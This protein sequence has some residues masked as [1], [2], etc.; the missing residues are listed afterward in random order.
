MSRNLIKL[1]SARFQCRSITNRLLS[2][3]YRFTAD[4]NSMTWNVRNLV[5]PRYQCKCITKCFLRLYNRFT[6]YYNFMT[7]NLRKLITPRFQCTSIKNRVFS[8]FD[9]FT[10]IFAISVHK[11]HKSFLSLTDR[12]SLFDQKNSYLRDFS[13]RVLI[14]LL[15]DLKCQKTH[16]SSI[17][18]HNYHKSCS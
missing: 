4:Y 13:A 8:L 17:S 2:L 14:T 7:W 15:Y 18:V 12:F 16:I 11:Y 3:F 5:S 9:R 10:A 6:A 1:V